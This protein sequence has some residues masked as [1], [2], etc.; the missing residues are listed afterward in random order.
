VVNRATLFRYVRALAEANGWDADA[1]TKARADAL[2]EA[3][4]ARVRAMGRRETIAI[5]PL[6]HAADLYAKRVRAAGRDP[7]DYTLADIRIHDLR[8]TLGSWATITGA[9]LSIVGRALGHRSLSA[10]QVYARLSVDPVREAVEAAASAIVGHGGDA[11][12]RV[13]TH[14]GDT[15]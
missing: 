12:A 4:R 1:E 11:A 8:R 3:E 6:G 7:A 14:Q 13:M 5:D 9:S 10:T 15:P 2:D